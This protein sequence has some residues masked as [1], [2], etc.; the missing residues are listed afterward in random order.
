MSETWVLQGLSYVFGIPG[1]DMG[2]SPARRTGGR[3]SGGMVEYVKKG[4]GVRIELEGQGV[5]GGRIRVLKY[6]IRK[7]R[8]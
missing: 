8:W 1:Y 5:E 7:G 3:P 4:G 2:S 6:G